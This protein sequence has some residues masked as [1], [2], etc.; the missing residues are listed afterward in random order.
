[1]TEENKISQPQKKEKK[2][3]EQKKVEKQAGAVE[4]FIVNNTPQFIKNACNWIIDRLPQRWG[5]W[6]RKNKFLTICIIYT[7]RGLF[8][9]P[10]MW[11][12]YASIFAYFQ[13]K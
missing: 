13:L 9:R 4:S 5:I 2:K 1:M 7:I 12:V 8:F 6:I 3:G 11:A 10:S